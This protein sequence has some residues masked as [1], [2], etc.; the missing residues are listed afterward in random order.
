ME[1]WQSPKAEASTLST[2]DRQQRAFLTLGWPVALG[3]AP[4]LL[5]LGD[6]PLC[7]FRQWTGRPCPLCGGTHACAALAE[8][9]LLAAWQANPGLMPLAAIA[10]AHTLQIAYEAW[11]GKRAVTWR[12]GP[13][14]WSAGGGFLLFAWVLRLLEIW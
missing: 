13:R 14:W 7:A 9:Q 2:A 4:L 11:S 6:V 10:A 5:S 1:P 8:G 12:V 3:A